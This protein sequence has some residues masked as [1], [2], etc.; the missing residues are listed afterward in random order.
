MG[1]SSQIEEELAM[2]IKVDSKNPKT[3][4][5]S[6]GKRHSVTRQPISLRRKGIKS[7]AEAK[8][9]FNEMVVE[10]QRRIEAK[11]I[12]TWQKLVIDFFEAARS[13][14]ISEKTL[15]THRCYFNAYT[16]PAWENRLVNSITT[17]EVLSMVREG[18]AKEKK[19]EV[20][21][22][23]LKC[24]RQAFQFALEGGYVVRNPA[25]QIK[26]KKSEKIKSVLTE[27]QMSLLLNKAREFEN[28]WYYH[29][30]MALYTGMRSGELYALTWD[31]VNLESKQILVDTAWNNVDGFKS[32][33]SG[34]DRVVEIGPGLMPVLM[35]L[36]LQGPGGGFVLPR[37]SKWDKGEQ[38]RELR[39]FLVGIGLPRVRFHD[40][41]A[42]WATL[43]LSK[44]V[45]PI[46]VMKLGGWQ[47]MKTMMIY[48]RKAG[49]DVKGATS[50]LDFHN[51]FTKK[52]DVYEIS[53]FRSDL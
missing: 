14:Q 27:P 31:K 35:D 6:Y 38:A 41:R 24:I 15:D 51:P 25:P 16:M 11:V 29:W 53:A 52:A 28:E 5:V 1:C 48:I 39:M 46:K 50:C 42:S 7:M 22:Y 37:L 10:V 26:F 4:V 23:L 49:V 20:Q 3:F 34:N 8:R 32:T 36:K 21:K 2:G 45:E 43:L 17:H 44:G 40:L 33:K 9:V 12:P 47:D 19:Q 18:L 13:R 30:A